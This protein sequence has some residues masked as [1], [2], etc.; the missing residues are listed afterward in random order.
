MA[1]FDIAQKRKSMEA[2]IAAYQWRINGHFQEID[3]MRDRIARLQERLVHLAEFERS[4]PPPVDELLR[5]C[6]TS[7]RRYRP[8]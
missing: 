2:D 5:M 6:H 8:R 7:C 3:V 1:E 4:L